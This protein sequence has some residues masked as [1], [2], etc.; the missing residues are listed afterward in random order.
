MSLS[1]Y[2]LRW[3]ERPVLWRFMRRS[4]PA[5][6]ER[7]SWLRVFAFM[8]LDATCVPLLTWP[9]LV[10]T[11][12][13]V[14]SFGP[15]AS[16]DVLPHL[17]LWFLGYTAEFGACVGLCWGLLSH[18]CWNHRAKQLTAT[19]DSLAAT[20]PWPKRGFLTWGSL[21]LIYL[22]LICVV[23]PLLLFHAIEN[24]RGAWA[25]RQMRAEL[26]AKGECFELPCV[27][28]PPAR[29]EDNFFATP[30]WQRFAYEQI[31]G[32]KGQ[33]T[34]KWLHPDHDAWATNFTLPNDP[35]PVIR[36]SGLIKKDPTD[37][38]TDLAAWAAK[39]REVNAALGDPKSRGQKM[40]FPVAA[41]PEKPADDVLLALSKFDAPLAELAA[42]APR[43]RNVYPI[44][45]EEDFNAL[46]P[47][48]A[49][50]KSITRI[51]VL[52]AVARL[53]AGDSEGAAADARLAFRIGES[54]NEDSLLINQLVRFACDGIAMRALWEGLADHRWS[55]AQL[56]AFQE[57]LG[58]RDYAKG[59]IHA[60]EGERAFG[61]DFMERMI[62]LKRW[63]A[64]TEL[65]RMMGGGDSRG[66]ESS[67]LGSILFMPSGWMRQNQIG[68]LRGH[69]VNLD[70]VRAV[71]NRTNRAAVLASNRQ[72]AN[73]MDDY[74]LKSAVNSSPFN[75]LAKMLL[76][77]LSKATAKADRAETVAQM[78]VVACALE[79][80]RLA[81]GSFP[82]ALTELVP[83]YLPAVPE[84]WMSGQPLH[85]ER[86]D[87]GLFRLWSVGP[88]GK[89]DGGVY[90]IVNK[91][92]RSLSEDLDW[93]WPQSVMSKE[94]R[95]F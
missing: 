63:N 24:T 85:Y 50:M 11:Y 83:A 72:Q 93:P 53:R 7:Y 42:A 39:F 13:M 14:R 69:Q 22:L 3:N 17:P 56:A 38:R 25:W 91:D 60:M 6:T 47:N 20:A 58:K 37:G 40:P 64:V 86:T 36:T 28:P 57:L 30:F 10:F 46:L 77:A 19:S 89:D 68:L 2:L 49:V 66:Q 71:M 94:P 75:I 76:P 43:P 84:D 21:G 55:D 34:I 8:V 35:E 87:D 61:N 31:K 32:E 15:S 82:V 33:T 29:D 59:I 51:S 65:D 41:T 44:H 27:I 48:L 5:R 12:L 1:E 62:R 18:L 80:H 81:H 23:T 26:K 45:Y 52:R 74:V 92:G 88:N 4:L 54:L 78:A 90:R 73:A 67:P 16:K 70:H 95:L 79:R 9:L